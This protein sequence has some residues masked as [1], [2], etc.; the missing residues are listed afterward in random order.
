MDYA[1]LHLSA[2]IL[3]MKFKC[4]GC[5]DCCLTAD[6]SGRFGTKEGFPCQYLDMSSGLCSIYSS[7][8]VGCAIFPLRIKQREDGDYYLFL[9]ALRFCGLHKDGRVFFRRNQKAGFGHPEGLPL[10]IA[11]EKPLIDVFGSRAYNYIK[12]NI[13]T[14]GLAIMLPKEYLDRVAKSEIKG[15]I[16]F[17]F[18]VNSEEV[19]NLIILPK[20]RLF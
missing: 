15:I 5:N 11:L 18:R 16:D 7:R 1:L 10:Y 3:R 12:E 17:D 4:A 8:P 6:E 14:N 9:Q 2:K 13:D 19:N 20:L